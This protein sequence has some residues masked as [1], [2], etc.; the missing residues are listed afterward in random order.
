MIRFRQIGQRHGDR[1]A[2]ARELQN[3]ARFILTDELA[4]DLPSLDIRPCAGVGDT[5]EQRESDERGENSFHD[6]F[7]ESGV[8]GFTAYTPEV[9]YTAAIT[10][11]SPRNC[12][13]RFSQNACPARGGEDLA[14]S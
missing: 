11:S 6:S 13:S 4:L 8:I 9:V 10:I 14:G 5:R 1:L 2:T 7:L 3:D 12:A